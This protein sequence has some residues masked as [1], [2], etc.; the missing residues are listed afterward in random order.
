MPCRHTCL[1]P[2]S[3]DFMLVEQLHLCLLVEQPHSARQTSPFMSALR[4]ALFLTA[5]WTVP[6]L[7]ARR[8]ALFLSASR[9][10]PFLSAR[11]TA[12][13]R[14]RIRFKDMKKFQKNLQY[15][16]HWMYN[17]APSV[18]IQF[19]YYWQKKPLTVLCSAAD[20]GCFSRIRNNN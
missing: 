2:A 10:A 13:L 4:T 11:R 15:F 12:P 17:Y 3:T 9:K 14:I 20:P 16:V 1:P 6:F 8:T 19:S 18:I 7:S 5:R